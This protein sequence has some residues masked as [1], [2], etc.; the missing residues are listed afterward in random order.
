MTVPAVALLFVWAFRMRGNLLGARSGFDGVSVREPP[1]DLKPALAAALAGR[2]GGPVGTLLDLA[3]RGVLKIE[4]LPKHWAARDFLITRVDESAPLSAH[5]NPL[6]EALF[7]ENSATVKMSKAAGRMRSAMSTMSEAVQREL[8]TAGLASPEKKAQRARTTWSM[9]VVGAL[10]VIAAVA[11]GLRSGSPEL[12]VLAGIGFGLTA[13]ISAIVI[14]G[15]PI[16]TD[17]G[18]VVSEQWKALVRYIRDVSR[19]REPL[20][21]PD[22]FERLLPYAAAFGVAAPWTKRFQKESEAPLPAWF[23]NLATDDGGA[24]FIA[25]T[26]SAD[27]AGAAG[28]GAAAGASGGGASGAG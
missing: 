18:S 26:S 6:M 24:A 16:W 27:S 12:A 17:Q 22:A 15:T 8:I 7:N 28:A 10:G 9:F 11:L 19:G 5:E 25:F 14:A 1:G 2:N 20:P 13:L 4:E 23:A 21:G 3:R